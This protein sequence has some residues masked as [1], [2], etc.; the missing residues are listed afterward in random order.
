[1][2]CFS[3]IHKT[4]EQKKKAGEALNQ[5]LKKYITS[6]EELRVL[7][8]LLS[9]NWV[10]QWV[11]KVDP[12]EFMREVVRKHFATKKQTMIGWGFLIDKI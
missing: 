7:L 8:L 5:Y 10:D 2:G 4:K 3:T 12:I 9:R 11:N 1:M 6:D